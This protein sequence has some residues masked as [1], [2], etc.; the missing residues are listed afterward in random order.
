MEH[1]TRQQI[2]DYSRNRLNAGEL[3]A[4][5]D[6]LEACETCREAA[7]AGL[8]DAAFFALHEQTL[9]EQPITHI[10][11]EQAAEYVDRNLAGEELQFVD[12]HLGSCEV[13]AFAVADLREFRNQIAPSLDREYRP[14][15]TPVVS[16]RSWREKFVSLFKIS[17][18]P[19]FASATLAV[20]FLVF[21]GWLA[22]RTQQD[23]KREVAVVPAP[24]LQPAASPVPTVQAQ[25]GPAPVVAQLN[26]GAV[27]VGYQNLV[28]KALSSQR[29]ERSSQ[30]QGLSRPS[31]SL[32]GANDKQREF[33][34][35]EP[36]GN[37]LLTNRP[38]FRWS[39]MEGATGYVVEVY[40]EQF[41]LVSSSPQVTSNSWSTVLPRGH[42]Y[43]WQVKAIKDG[44]ETTVP[45]PPAPQAKFRV[46][47]ENRASEIERARKAYASS[48]LM[49]ALLY[50]D[51][52]LVKEAE[53][54][55]RILKRANPQSEVVTKLLRQVQSMRTGLHD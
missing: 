48:H 25:P 6:H 29:I 53:G 30:L 55:L 20:L 47:D 54:E 4:A 37:V 26:D 2:E 11:D 16:K 36:A 44:E 14:A 24:T 43:S 51:A 35:A 34:V 33:S 31:S 32:M 13:C 21:I 9:D 5:S 45:R 50:A 17:P 38:T 10:T 39:S 27:P 7:E 40:D 1:L 42:V 18:V 41:K 22:W 46:L 28:N 12:D 49:L 19:A 8:T 52:G 15:E 23:D 3:L